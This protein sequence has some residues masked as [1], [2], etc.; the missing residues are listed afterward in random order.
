LRNTYSETGSEPPTHAF[1]VPAYRHSDYL[2]DCL[3]SLSSQTLKSAVVVS[4]STPYQGLQDLCDKFGARLF[5]HGPN[6]GIGPDWNA[7][8]ACVQADL[9]TLAHQDDRYLPTFVDRMVDH[10]MRYS[11]SAFYFCDADEITEDGQLR[12]V[13]TNNRVKRWM[14]GAAFLGRRRVSDAMSKRLLLGFGNPI[15][16]PS[17]TLNRQARPGFRFREDLRTNMDWIAWL[18]LAAGASVTHVPEVLMHHR[19]HAQSETA[20]C[21]D[22]GARASEDRMAFETLWPRSVATALMWLYRRSYEGYR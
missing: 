3:A 4:T 9:V 13:A 12:P 16:C 8:I 7:A 10:A 17:V 5:V 11:D 18:D 15:V 14:V 2:S 22:D 6:R 20:R 19:V 21:L 1:V